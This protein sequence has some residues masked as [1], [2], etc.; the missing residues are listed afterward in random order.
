MGTGEVLQV[1]V[2]DM[3]SAYAAPNAKLCAFQR[4]F[5]SGGES[6]TLEIK[7][8]REAFTVVNNEGERV[9]EGRRFQVSVGLGQPDER[10]RELTG[11]EC[12]TFIV[13]RR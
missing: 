4:F 13:E 11:K 8:D 1:Y 3:E 9:T 7:L 2:K 5:L 12:I 6:G 10:T